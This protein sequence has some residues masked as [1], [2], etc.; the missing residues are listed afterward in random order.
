M[1]ITSP[2]AL[3]AQVAAELRRVAGTTPV[4]EDV[5]EQA[6]PPYYS[7][8]Y[9]G[10]SIETVY[11]KEDPTSTVPH[12]A[13]VVSHSLDI[14]LTAA[15]EARRGSQGSGLDVLQAAVIPVA[16]TLQT[17]SELGWTWGSIGEIE[18]DGKGESPPRSLVM[19]LSAEE[20]ISP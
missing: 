4:L 13:Y 7:V 3:V 1:A 15:F 19:T 6:A 18:E 10:A 8:S 17:T 9:G 20:R 5:R 2:D 12:N 11:N 16:N 14:E